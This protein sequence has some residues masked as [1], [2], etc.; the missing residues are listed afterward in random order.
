VTKKKSYMGFILGRR[1]FPNSDINVDN[2]YFVSDVFNDVSG[3]FQ[4]RFVTFSTTFVTFKRRFVKIGSSSTT[5]VEIDHL[6]F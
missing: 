4:R 6:Y 1:Q 3:R 5:K 2:R